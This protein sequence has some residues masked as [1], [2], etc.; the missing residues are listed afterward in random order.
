M[1]CLLR[2]ELPIGGERKGR[3]VHDE[4]NGDTRDARAMSGAEEDPGKSHDRVR[5]TRRLSLQRLSKGTHGKTRT[6]T[7]RPATDI[8][9]RIQPR[10]KYK[11]HSPSILFRVHGS[12][13]S[14][15]CV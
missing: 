14:V 3:S 6:G 13:G 15:L 10:S 1:R 11:I 8:R 7:L 12:V 2:A 9:Q 4:C 5:R